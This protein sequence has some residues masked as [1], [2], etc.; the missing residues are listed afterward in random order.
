MVGPQDLPV[1]D[2]NVLTKTLAVGPQPDIAHQQPF[3]FI[4]VGRRERCLGS[5]LPAHHASD[6][7][8]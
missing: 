8:R 5:V 6:Y 3:R 2:T 1:R 4:A 7:Q